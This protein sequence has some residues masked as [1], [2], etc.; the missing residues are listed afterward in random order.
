MARTVKVIPTYRSEVEAGTEYGH[1]VLKELDALSVQIEDAI[2]QVETRVEV[3]EAGRV[4]TLII[5]GGGSAITTG[6]KADLY[7]PFAC[8]ITAATLLADQTGSIVIDVWID[9]YGNF[10]PTD[11]DSITASSPPTI[12]SSVKSQDATLSGWTTAIAAGDTL[13][14]NVDSVSTIERVTLALT[15]TTV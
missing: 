9:T 6:V 1:V 4:I 11:A 8:T 13:R 15:V 12:T 7:I 14:F 10:P 5:D 3:L 2:S